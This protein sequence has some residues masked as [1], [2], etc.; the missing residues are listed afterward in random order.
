MRPLRIVGA[1][2][3]ESESADTDLPPVPAEPRAAPSARGA[4][5]LPQT[6]AIEEVFRFAG[7]GQ[8]YRI[9]V[10]GGT[11]SGKTWWQRKLVIASAERDDLV[12]VHDGKDRT[13]QYR[14]AIRDSAFALARNPTQENTIVFRHENPERVAEMAWQASAKGV[15]SLVLIDEIYDAIGGDRHWKALKTSRIDEIYRKGRSRGVSIAGSTQIPQSLPTVAIDLA[16]FKVI[17]KLDSRS[18]N[19][20]AKSFKLTPDL[21]GTIRRLTVGQFV[22]VQQGVDWNGVIYGPN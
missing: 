10:I 22:L 3:E 8:G 18:L 2:T 17:F 9:T 1:P 13:P 11:G 19:Y 5:G 4:K 6:A 21:V 12:L 15:T 20:V 16:D 7:T 14:G